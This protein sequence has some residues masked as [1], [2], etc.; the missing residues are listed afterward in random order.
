M[1]VFPEDRTCP[2]EGCTLPLLKNGEHAIL[3]KNGHGLISRHNALAHQ[4]TSFCSKAFLQPQ[5]EK[6]LGNRGPG[7]ALTRPADVFLPT[8]SLE[9]GVLA[10]GM[11]LDF[12][13]T[14]AQQ[15]KYLD[16]VRTASL[17]T[18][19][20]F[21]GQYAETK[22]R[23]RQEAEDAGHLF[24]AMVV[25]S[26]GSWSES[27]LSVLRNIGA[28]RANASKELLSRS[29]ARNDLLTELNIALMRSQTRMMVSRICVPD[30][31]DP[32]VVT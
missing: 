18:P 17:V 5:R 23:Q 22:A 29:Q 1:D 27:A 10:Q 15:M 13:V 8:G 30:P 11:V 16:L 2:A 19:G 31:T 6:S 32:M 7:G 12:A 3:C 4:F 9:K 20:S 28:Q 24:E 14:H 21:A 26:F 25:E